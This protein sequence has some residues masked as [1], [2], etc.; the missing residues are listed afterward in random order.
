LKQAALAVRTRLSD[1]GLS[2]FLKTTGGK[3]LHLLVPLAPTKDWSFVKEF[4][5]A[6]ADSIVREKPD[7]YVAT[8][9]KAKRKRKIF[10]DYLRN[11]K[12]AT[13]VC[14]YSTRARSGAPVSLPIRWDELRRDPRQ[15][16]T[17]QTTLKRLARLGKDPWAGYE[18]AR[19]PLTSEMMNAITK[20]SPR[21]ANG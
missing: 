11:A 8:M 21:R 19:A 7:H 10:I 9:S 15:D 14:A 2:A 3:G 4:A 12:T 13:A 16:F 20:A 6:V 17:I 1:V 18:A 5:K